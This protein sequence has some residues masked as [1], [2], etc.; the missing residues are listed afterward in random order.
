[1]T[2]YRDSPISDSVTG[3]LSLSAMLIL[4][5]KNFMPSTFFN[6]KD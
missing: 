3:A 6:R 4:G 5:A 2:E 1:M